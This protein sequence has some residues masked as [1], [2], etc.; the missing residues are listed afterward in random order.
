MNTH[1]DVI[2]ATL[3]AGALTL[4]SAAPAA[5]GP[6]KTVVAVTPD[7]G[8]ER[9]AGD[10]GTGTSLTTHKIIAGLT[11]DIG[12]WSLNATVPYLRFTV[13]A[14]GTIIVG[15][16]PVTRPRV[17]QFVSRRRP[18]PA[19][20][21]VSGVGDVSLG[22][23]YAHALGNS[24]WS[25]DGGLGVKLANGDEA[26]GLGTGTTEPTAYLGA[27]YGKSAWSL[28]G[29]A[30]YTRRESDEFVA[31]RNSAAGSLTLSWRPAEDW[32]L[33]VSGLAG[34]PDI[35]GG[36]GVRSA[37]LALVFRPSAHAALT[38]SFTRGLSDAGA[39]SVAGLSF[40]YRF[41]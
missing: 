41:E 1:R 9:S 40:S 2:H 30:S 21:E 38:A 4:A 3:A 27:T 29:E 35:E 39:D 19:D 20:T 13:P 11:L 16:R 37:G 28:R 5:P 10:Y 7:F 17:Q 6:D 34:Q 25:L 12:D 18:P 32:D 26:Q 31:W 36:E 8:Y 14:D 15:G 24:A 33:R 23:A 22:L